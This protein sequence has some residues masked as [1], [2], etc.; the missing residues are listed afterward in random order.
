MGTKK[1]EIIN[2]D[3]IDEKIKLLKTM[4]DINAGILCEG[5][6]PKFLKHL[7]IQNLID[8]TIKIV[9]LEKVVIVGQN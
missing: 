3:N 4:N 2:F 7:A 1:T 5:N 6:V 9:N 8:N